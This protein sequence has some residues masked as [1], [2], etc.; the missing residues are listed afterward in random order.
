MVINVIEEQAVL[1]DKIRYEC[2]S[3]I[4]SVLIFTIVMV[5]CAVISFMLQGS[6]GQIEK[7][8]AKWPKE[9]L[10][11]CGITKLG[12]KNLKITPF[13]M[14]LIIT[15]IIAICRCAS[16]GSEFMVSDMESGRVKQYINQPFN[17]R[18]IYWIRVI[19]SSLIAVIHWIIYFLFE[20]FFTR[21]MCKKLDIVS[22]YELEAIRGMFGKS[23]VCVLLVFSICLL[24]SMNEK[25]KMSNSNF[26]SLICICSFVAGNM[27]KIFELI[28]YYMRRQQINDKSVMF[29]ADRLERIRFLFPFTALNPLNSEKHPLPD[30]IWIWCI[31]ITIGLLGLS[32]YIF[33]KKDFA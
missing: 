31:I 3:I 22:K 32:R 18:E 8:V 19:I 26:L 25:R 5:I 30:G 33:G 24:Y 28:G 29:V 27:Y 14:M 7:W 4:K 6:M 10:A 2:K 17:R 16:V 9:L 21:F 1:I 11:L 13:Y 15:N 20:L 23:V 12:V